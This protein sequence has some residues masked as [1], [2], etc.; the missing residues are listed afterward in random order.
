MLIAVELGQLFVI[1][2]EILEFEHEVAGFILTRHDM[3]AASKEI[4]LPVNHS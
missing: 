3:Q 4:G 1:I 2:K